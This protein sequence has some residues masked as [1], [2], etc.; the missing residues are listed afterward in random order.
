MRVY[1]LYFC[2][3]CY[4]LDCDNCEDV[5]ENSLLQLDPKP[6]NGSGIIFWSYGRSGTGS[7]KKSLVSATG[8]KY[9]KGKG[10]PFSGHP[11]DVKSL[12][13]CILNGELLL[14]VKP[15]HLYQHGGS[16]QSP[17]KFFKAAYQVAWWARIFFFVWFV[18]SL[19]SL[20][21]FRAFFTL[22]Y[23]A[24][25]Q[26][27]EGRVELYCIEGTWNISDLQTTKRFLE[28][29]LWSSKAGFRIVV[30]SFRENQ[31][32]R[33]LSS[34]ELMTR[35]SRSRDPGYVIQANGFVKEKLGYP[36]IIKRYE[37]L[38]ANYNLGLESAYN[39]GFTIVPLS[40]EDLIRDTCQC[41][42]L[43]L[44]AL[45]QYALP[46]LAEC[47][48]VATHI[49]PPHI[50]QSVV[51]ATTEE[52]GSIIK[53]ELIGTPYEWMLDLDANDWPP[54]VKPQ[55]PVAT[56]HTWELISKKSGRMLMYRSWK[57][58]YL[59]RML[60]VLGSKSHW[61]IFGPGYL[62]WMGLFFYTYCFFPKKKHDI[63]SKKI[64]GPYQWTPFS[65]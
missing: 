30:G 14:M 13:D 48:A 38:R 1:F 50:N 37:E 53:G 8:Y 52:V 45:Q 11:P 25:I 17:Q 22:V 27:A 2:A 46:H 42:R 40:F 57:I 9:C 54:G 29:T 26:H 61:P 62:N 65:I 34:F 56:W 20:H 41:V 55:F 19:V 43:T 64:M 10:E 28:K 58:R 23:M 49:S 7:F 15:Q 6:L 51:S 5:S 39:L 4:A 21:G 24:W 12:R 18:V 3:I 63:P 59:H 32:A 35:Q 60:D 36:G 31:L 47:H 16:L 44:K 33:D